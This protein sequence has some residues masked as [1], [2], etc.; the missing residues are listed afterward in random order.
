MGDSDVQT[1][2]SPPAP[3][4]GLEVP[5]NLY[6]SA[7]L[8]EVVRSATALWAAAHPSGQRGEMRIRSSVP[9]SCT[10]NTG[11]DAG[12]ATMPRGGR[13]TGPKLGLARRPAPAAAK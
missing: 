1:S 9:R 2:R 10:A 11:E 3:V 5:R 13:S 12:T 7:V 4:R 6:R 8:G